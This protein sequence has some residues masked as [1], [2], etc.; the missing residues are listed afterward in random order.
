MNGLTSTSI[1]V[2]GDRKYAMLMKALA[3]KRSTSV[4]ALVRKALD[5]HYGG[6]L[7]A[8]LALFDA[9]DDASNPQIGDES[10]T[11]ESHAPAR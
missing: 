1:P 2:Q 5:D 11:E 3:A 9:P 8:L 4:A 6:E 7:R 10:I